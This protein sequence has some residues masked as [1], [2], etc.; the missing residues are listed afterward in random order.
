[1]KSQLSIVEKRNIY[2]RKLRNNYDLSQKLGTKDLIKSFVKIHK[3]FKKNTLC[4]SA[5]DKRKN[6]L[7]E[8]FS[9]SD[10][11][12]FCLSHNSKKFFKVLKNRK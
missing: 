12:Y 7:N 4:E 8:Y 9:N 10:K 11:Y 6:S 3:I 2:Q 1:M 5:Y